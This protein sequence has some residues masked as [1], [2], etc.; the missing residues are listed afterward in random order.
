VSREPEGSPH[1]SVV[2]PTHDRARLLREVVRAWRSV[3][4]SSAS[5]EV[6]V[7][8]DGSS[9]DTPAVL[10]ALATED[11]RVPVRHV[12]QPRRGLA[13]ARNAGIEA[14]RGRLLM[15]C[16]D[17]MLPR[18]PDV[19]ARHLARQ[20]AQP[21]AWVSRLVVPDE[22]VRTPFQAYWRRRLEG[23]TARYR[24]GS[25]LGIG[26]FWFATLSLP[27]E[28]L[29]GDRFTEEFTGYGWEE[30]ELGYRLHRRGV[31]A[32]FL[33]SAQVEHRDAVDFHSMRDKF[34]RMGEAAWT[35]TRLHPGREVA[36]WTGTHG[37]SRA[38]KRLVGQERRAARLLA[39]RSVDELTDSQYALCLE[40]A[41][42]QGLREGRP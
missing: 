35:F 31:R 38:V 18:S 40:A 12:R 39:G 7:V 34:R 30:H 10:A 20:E 15:F 3:A 9:D 11:H 28:L 21:D 22:L 29:A 6:V 27:R 16:D 2:V 37:V 42:A 1:V 17:D 25:R 4:P 13:A 23:G 8:D 26:G 5:V 14:A 41:Y 19:M 24:D 33:R 36:L 32:R